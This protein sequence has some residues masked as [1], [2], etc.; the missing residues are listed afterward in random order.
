VSDVLALGLLLYPDDGT[1]GSDRFFNDQARNLFLGFAMYLLATPERP[2]TMGELLR[3]SSATGGGDMRASLRNMLA[4][5]QRSD[6][7]LRDECIEAFSRFLAAPDNTSGSILSTF[8]AVLTMWADQTVDAAMSGNSFDLRDLR[9]R[10]TTVYLHVPANRR[11]TARLLINIFFSQLIEL[12]TETTPDRDKSLRLQ[13]LLLLD[14]FPSLGKVSA[15]SDS[16]AYLAGYNLRLLT[17][18]QAHSQLVEIYGEHAAH[19]FVAN[20]GLQVLYTPRELRDSEEYSKRLGTAD[21][22]TSSRSRSHSYG[23]SSSSSSGSNRSVQARALLM[24]QEFRAMPFEKEVIDLEGCRPI[25]AQKILYWK[26]ARFADRL[27]PPP[28]VP[29]LKLDLHRARL[30]GRVKPLPTITDVRTTPLEAIDVNLLGLELPIDPTPEQ[31]AAFN[32]TFYDRMAT[33]EA[34]PDDDFDDDAPD[35]RVPRHPRETA[36]PSPSLS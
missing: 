7:K 20:H 21:F 23:K 19:N 30:E 34:A 26:D 11:G 24:P 6:R 15:I 1:S 13:V 35:P 17:I 18:A 4:E 29:P 5:R 25:D 31:I 32:K 27:L 10:P 9:R 2:R 28:D 22:E 16:I 12:S 36:E 8:H 3:L 33:R 14:E